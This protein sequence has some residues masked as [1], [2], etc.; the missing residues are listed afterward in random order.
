MFLRPTH[1]REGSL[2]RYTNERL[3]VLNVSQ[4]GGVATSMGRLRLLPLLSGLLFAAF[5]CRL[6]YEGHK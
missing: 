3:F 6:E 2:S 5:E 1:F 4:V